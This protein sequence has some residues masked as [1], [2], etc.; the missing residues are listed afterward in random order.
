[1][2][3]SGSVSPGRGVVARRQVGV[4][5]GM[6]GL[7]AA[8]DSALRRRAAAAAAPRAAALSARA[9]RGQRL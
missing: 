1:M 6:G 2:F 4:V 5:L 9:Q 7:L 8:H 3:V